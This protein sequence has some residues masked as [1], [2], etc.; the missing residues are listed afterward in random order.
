VEHVIFEWPEH[1]SADRSFRDRDRTIKGRLRRRF[2]SLTGWKIGFV[3]RGTTIV[4]GGGEVHQFSHLI[5]TAP[6]FRPRS[7][8]G[9]GKPGSN[10][11]DMRKELREA[12]NRLDQRI[13]E[14]SGL[15]TVLN[16]QGTIF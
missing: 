7:P 10:F 8:N 2:F 14:P 15:P 4:A 13:G 12:G 1:N 5:R 16:R 9:L 3:L 6:I 11:F